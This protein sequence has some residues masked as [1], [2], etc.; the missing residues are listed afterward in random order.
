M[1]KR[2]RGK[3]GLTYGGGESRRYRR[4]GFGDIGNER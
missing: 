2:R 1:E 3:F 4:E